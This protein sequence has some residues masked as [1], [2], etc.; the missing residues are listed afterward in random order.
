MGMTKTEQTRRRQRFGWAMLVVAGKVEGGAIGSGGVAELGRRVQEGKAHEVRYCVRHARVSGGR[1][2]VGLGATGG[3][4]AGGVRGC[5]RQAKMAGY[6]V[7]R[8]AVRSVCVY[9][10]PSR[11][12]LGVAT[13]ST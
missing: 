2:G 8:S 9:A 3:G 11:S 12:Q 6:A 13:P 1:A 5:V 4:S 10:A 7:G